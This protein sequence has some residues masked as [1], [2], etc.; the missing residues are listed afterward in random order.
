MEESSLDETI[1]KASHPII[2]DDFSESICERDQYPSLHSNAWHREESSPIKLQKPVSPLV[3][4]ID[5]WNELN[6]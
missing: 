1:D 3:K 5:H 2:I 4:D 6:Q